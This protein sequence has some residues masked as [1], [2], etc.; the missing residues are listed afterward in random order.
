M[1]IYLILFIKIYSTM[2]YTISL[3]DL[4]VML[5]NDSL[6]NYMYIALGNVWLL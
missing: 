5:L 2:M 4:Y 6:P 3:V 1:G